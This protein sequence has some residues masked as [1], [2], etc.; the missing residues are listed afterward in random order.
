MRTTCVSCT[1]R[2]DCADECRHTP[3]HAPLALVVQRAEQQREEQE[4]RAA[5]FTAGKTAYERGNYPASVRL[6]E[7]ALSEAGAFTQ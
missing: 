5:Q 1:W 2:A 7:Q 4:A 6:L 3:L